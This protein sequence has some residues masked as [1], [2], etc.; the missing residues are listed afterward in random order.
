MSDVFEKLCGPFR[1]DGLHWRAQTVTFKD[2]KYSALA[3]AYMDARDVMARLDEVVGAENWQDEYAET[4][5]G[6]VICTL[7]LRID[8]EWIAKSDGAGGTDIEG[9]KGGISDA[10]KRAAVKWGVG[11]YLYDLETPWVECAGVSKGDKHYFRKW[12][13]SALARFNKIASSVPMPRTS[14][15]DGGAQL[16]ID[17]IESCETTMALQSIWTEA[18]DYVRQSPEKDRITAI[19]DARKAAIYEMEKIAA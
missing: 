16:L 17:R 6:R 19:K 7:R 4:P 8:G 14:E 18:A 11:R 9:D 12:L 15:P 13:P 2:G 5:T 1:A 3:L 10:F